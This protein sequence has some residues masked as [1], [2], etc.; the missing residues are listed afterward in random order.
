MQDFIEDSLVIMTKSTM[1]AFLATDNYVE[2]VSLYSFYYYTAKWQKTNQPKCTTEYVSKALGW[3]IVKVRKFKKMLADMGLIE[4]VVAKDNSGRVSG[5]Y[6]KIKYVV[7]SKKVSDISAEIH[8]TKKPRGGNE[9]PV[10]NLGDKCLKNKYNK[11]LKK[12]NKMLNGKNEK[13][14]LNW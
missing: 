13:S 10:V 11:C 6:I 1:D 4:D 8:P 2:L 14:K 5:H 3:N 9:S 7:S 12:N